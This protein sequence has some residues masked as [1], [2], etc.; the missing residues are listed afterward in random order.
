MRHKRR[1]AIYLRVSTSLQDTAMQ[2]SELREWAE[3]RGWEAKIYRDNGQSGA[4][5]SRP[6]LESLL[7]DVKRGRVDVVMVWSLDRLARSLKQLLTL[8]EEFQSLGVDLY[9]HK[10]AIDTSSPS[11]RLTYQVLGAV[12]EFEREML[13]ER[14]RAGLAQARRAGKKIGRPPLRRFA[15]S[16]IAEIKA[17]RQSGAS[18]RGLAIQFKTTQYVINK[19]AAQ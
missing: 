3:R 12:A 17:L 9:S 11:G 19:L 2:E 16:E 7:A 8:A 14:V 18:V 10:Q 13:R 1:A 6:A 5:E 4:K 15:S